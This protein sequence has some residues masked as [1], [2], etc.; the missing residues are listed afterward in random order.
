MLLGS[1]THLTFRNGPHAQ[2]R[3]R[4]F[5]LSRWLHR[6]FNQRAHPGCQQP[7]AA[8]PND[9]WPAEDK[10]QFR[11][12]NGSYCFPL[13]VRDLASRYILGVDA[14]PAISLERG[15]V[16]F[17]RLFEAYGLPK[18]I[19]TDN[20]ILFASNALAR[21]SERS[22]WFTPALAAHIFNQFAGASEDAWDA[23]TPPAYSV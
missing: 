2:T 9:I 17:R 16:H 21:L 11:P 7:K 6:C 20:G 13:T 8:E 1:L 15:F 4:D 10:G 23:P 5:A 18:R 22:V 19:R 14:H 12:K 3:V